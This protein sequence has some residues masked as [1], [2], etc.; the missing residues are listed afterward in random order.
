MYVLCLAGWKIVEGALM[1]ID[2]GPK[3]VV[4]GVTKGMEIYC[5]L[6]ITDAMH[7]GSKWEKI[8]G[9][10]KYISC[11]AYGYWGVAQNNEIYFT[12]L[13]SGANTKW[14]KIDGS[15]TQIEA[16]PNGQVWGVNVNKELY[17]RIGVSRSSPSGFK[18]KKIGSRSFISVTIGLNKLYAIDV[19]YTVYMGSIVRQTS[20]GLCFTSVQSSKWWSTL[21]LLTASLIFYIFASICK[22][23]T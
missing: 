18:W 16:G 15:L 10:L 11:G 13:M 17:T 3:G 12:A 2:S 4:C 21:E 6:G 19:G 20:P 22:D 14:S 7:T 1:Q 9:S 5:R 23:T 8:S